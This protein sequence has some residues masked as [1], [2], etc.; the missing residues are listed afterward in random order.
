MAGLALIKH[1]GH[2][3][4]TKRTSIFCICICIFVSTFIHI[5]LYSDGQRFEQM[6]RELRVDF[7]LVAVVQQAAAYGSLSVARLGLFVAFLC[8]CTSVPALSWGQY[9]LLD[10]VPAHKNSPTGGGYYF[11][12]TIHL[13]SVL[14]ASS[15]VRAG[16]H[17]CDAV[18]RLCP[19]T[20]LCPRCSVGGRLCQ[21]EGL[22]LRSVAMGDRAAH[23]TSGGPTPVIELGLRKRA[24]EEDGGAGAGADDTPRGDLFTPRAPPATLLLR[25]PPGGSGIDG[26]GGV[27]AALGLGCLDAG[28]LLP[29]ARYTGAPLPCC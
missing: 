14:N 3:L 24:R 13:P 26:G 20:R 18:T 10:Q 7:V 27:V 21:S 4:P 12:G 11:L 29:V 15:V 5:H 9:R 2:G 17:V 23:A 25:A 22:R 8:V 16:C 28:A 6:Q 19:S 1:Q